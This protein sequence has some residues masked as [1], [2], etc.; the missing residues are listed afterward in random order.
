MDADGKPVVFATYG[1]AAPYLGER[2]GRFCSYCERKIPASLAV[3]HVV[4]KSHKPELKKDWGNFLLACA[5]CNSHKGRQAVDRTAFLW[6]DTDDT[7]AAFTYAPSG[8]I[9]VAAS[10]DSH[11]QAKAQA[12]LSLVGLDLPPEQATAAD[13]RHKDRLEQWGKARVALDML[14]R[15]PEHDRE[16]TRAAIVT[17]ATDGYSIWATVFR[18]DPAV[19]RALQQKYPGTRVV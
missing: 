6:P 13:Y 11:Q 9:K 3:E 2:L 17:L 8:A 18:D 15:A 19:L 14:T 12:L 4:P 7:L 5:N 1:D 16:K 10:L